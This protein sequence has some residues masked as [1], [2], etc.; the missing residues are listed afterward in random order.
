[1]ENLLGALLIFGLRIIDVSIG[2]VRTMFTVRGNRIV[3]G[4]L[5]VIESGVFIFAISR[6]LSEAGRD[7]LR[8]A[9]Y[10]LGF[11]TGTVLGITI[12]KW[13]ASGTILV[14]VISPKHV[15]RLRASLLNEGFG[16]TA[17]RGEGREGEVVILFIVAPR[18]RGKQVLTTINEIDPDAFVTIEP[19]SH[20]TGGF[21]PHHVDPSSVKK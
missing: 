18:R 15:I 9:G 6:V 21:M 13:I 8:M 5:G 12:E 11:A 19:I 3:A 20:A 4:L 2:T 1:M 10:A 17:V 14:R 7:P 16:V